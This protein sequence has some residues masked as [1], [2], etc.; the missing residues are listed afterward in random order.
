[1]VYLRK[2]GA[3]GLMIFRK[4]DSL[5]KVYYTSFVWLIVIPLLL[6][7]FVAIGVLN[8]M[9]RDLAVSNIENA[10][11]SMME[12]LKKDISEASL[13]LSHLVYVNG[14]EFMELAALTDTPDH[15]QKNE[16]V[17]KLEDIFQV[18]ATPKQDIIA[19]QFYMK[20][21]LVTSIK[22]E[23]TLSTEEIK[24]SDWYEAALG[25][26][27]VVS[28]GAYD[29]GVRSLT[30]S[31]TKK[32][33]MIIV[34]ALS[35]DIALDRSDRVE[36]VSLFYRSSIGD[37]IR[38]Y[39]R[40]E[41]LG[42]TVLVDESGEEVYRGYCGEE[43]LWYPR[44]INW[45]ES[46]KDGVYSKRVLSGEG[47]TMQDYTYVISSLPSVGWRLVTFVPTSALTGEF[48]RVV[49]ILMLVILGLLFL[50]YCFSRYFLRNIL[51]PVQT[52]V[53][54]M[55]Q[56]EQGDL[57][58]HLEPA[59]QSEI[60]RMI[61]SFN[62]MVRTLRASI[63]EKERAQEMKH[64]AEIRALQSQINPHFLVNTLNS[65]RF[66]AQVSKFDGLRKMAEALIKIVSCSFRSN[67]SFYSLKEELEVLDSY[68][69]LMKIRYSD[70]FEV[71]YQIDPQCLDCLVP[72]LILQPLAENSIVHGFT[73]EEVGHLRVSAA[74]EEEFL[75][76]RVWD[77]GRGMTR[78]QIAQVL[79]GKK[80]TENDNTSIGLENVIARLKLN[81][82]EK[83]GVEF[84]S[85][86]D[87]YTEI[88][89]RLPWQTEKKQE[90]QEKAK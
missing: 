68:I 34:S 38:E 22:D 66:M 69:Y 90:E 33:E 76:L 10:Q 64:E 74:K 89:L 72:R 87:G 28:I 14:G 25:K 7:F 84:D 86:P 58:T 26:K 29:T 80:R 77:D 42:K 73:G 19:S 83:C 21:G 81:F 31:R 2:N 39:E 88:T 17:R 52:V 70:G 15:T 53:S 35:P 49:L 6:V 43:D 12:M 36:L 61:H 54:G 78:E 62:Q 79:E 57:M 82:G 56:V 16:N 11:A 65:I 4:H 8:V 48:R 59:G 18:A 63:T 46:A 24:M 1:M 13:Q 45:E 9:M 40:S 50:F 75:A 3:E 32:W 71:E 44:Q 67:I 23:M 55:E 30:Q 60:R 51:S 85:E 20:D 5:K 37:L 27:N 47:G 41:P